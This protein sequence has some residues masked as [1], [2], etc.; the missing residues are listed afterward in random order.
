MKAYKYLATPWASTPSTSAPTD[1]E[2]AA[3][4]RSLLHE[5]TLHTASD[6]HPRFPEML[7]SEEAELEAESGEDEDEAA[8]EGAET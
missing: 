7:P 3:A 8:E 6:M 2:F 1:G 5:S 4:A